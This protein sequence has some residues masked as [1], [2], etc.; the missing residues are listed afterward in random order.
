MRQN[1][2]IQ[3]TGLTHAHDKKKAH[4]WPD[5]KGKT[6][7]LVHDLVIKLKLFQYVTCSANMYSFNSLGKLQ[8]GSFLIRVGAITF[9]SFC[10]L[11]YVDVDVDELGAVATNQLPWPMLFV[12]LCFEMLQKLLFEAYFVLYLWTSLAQRKCQLNMPV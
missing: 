3:H 1:I 2:H 5:K 7:S 4:R 11:K 8:L 9:H 6:V 12:F 10:Q